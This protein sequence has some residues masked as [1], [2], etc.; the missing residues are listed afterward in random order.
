MRK[1]KTILAQDSV[2]NQGQKKKKEKKTNERIDLI[3]AKI[4]WKASETAE[5][6]NVTGINLFFNVDAQ[7]LATEMN[8]VSVSYWRHFQVQKWKW[9]A[10]KPL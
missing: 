1:L 7:I 8:E 3:D 9:Y 5:L 10:A 2:Y 6:S 4:T